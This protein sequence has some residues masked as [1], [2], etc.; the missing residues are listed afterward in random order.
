MA[1]AWTNS[2]GRS[3]VTDARL[4]H[5]RRLRIRFERRAGIHQAFP[6]PGCALVCRHIFRRTEQSFETAFM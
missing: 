3:N 1:V 5:F 6:E 2:A 4:H